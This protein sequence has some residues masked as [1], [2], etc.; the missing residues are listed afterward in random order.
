MLCVE[1]FWQNEVQEKN[2]TLASSKK[3]HM[4]K[5]LKVYINVKVVPTKKK[6]HSWIR[7]SKNA[8][9]A[10]NKNENACSPNISEVVCSTKIFT[11]DSSQDV[12]NFSCE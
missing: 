12:L 6:V 9:E 4:P 3:T 8:C 1:N 11:E 5:K 2:N 10:S 7:L